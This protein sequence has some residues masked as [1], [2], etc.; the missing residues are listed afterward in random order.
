M[1]DPSHGSADDPAGALRE[2]P[3]PTDPLETAELRLARLRLRSRRRGLR[4]MDLLLGAFADAELE[5]LPPSALAEYE[6]LLSE[7]DQDLYLWVS[8][9]QTSPARHRAIL[10]RIAAFHGIE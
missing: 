7:N 6:L 4:E 2:P 8:R 9:P 3:G 1:P 10:W 5:T